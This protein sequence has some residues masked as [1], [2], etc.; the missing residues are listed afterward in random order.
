MTH[1]S[2]NPIIAAIDCSIVEEQQDS[3]R[4]NWTLDVYFT[5]GGCARQI[6]SDAQYNLSDR[7]GIQHFI[8]PKYVERVEVQWN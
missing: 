1:V 3:C 4:L 5:S 2:D 6:R 8:N 7:S